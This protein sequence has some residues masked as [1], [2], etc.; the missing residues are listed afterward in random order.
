M[1]NVIDMPRPKGVAAHLEP[2]PA[3][4]VLSKQSPFYG[5]E[6]G[7]EI[8]A[9]YRS[10]DTRAVVGKAIH[11]RGGKD[12][13]SLIYAAIDLGILKPT[14]AA[15]KKPTLRL[16]IPDAPPTYC[17]KYDLRNRKQRNHVR[18]VLWPIILANKDAVIANPRDLEA[19]INAGM[20]KQQQVVAAAKRQY[21]TKR[22]V[23]V[24]TAF[25][26]RCRF[27]GSLPG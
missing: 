19:I 25:A 21:E 8:A 12:V 18:N 9:T 26:R 22:Q 5:V 7:E 27:S 11:D 20:Q 15:T 2:V 24:V 6:R 1:T 17:A 10:H 23:A 16:L 14:G 3:P 13:L 4:L